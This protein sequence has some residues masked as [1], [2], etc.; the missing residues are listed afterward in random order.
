MN[1]N[2]K[3]ILILNGSLGGAEG[4]SSVLIN[5][6]IE[7]LKKHS[8]SIEVIH[9]KNNQNDLEAKLK[10]ADGF[11]FVSGTY[12]DSWGSPLQLFLEKS[13]EYEASD[14]FLYKP[15]SVIITM[16]SVGGKAILSR[17]QGV[18]NTIGMLI[19]PMSGL[20]YSLATHLNL[21]K[22][23]N[24]EDLSFH[25]DFWNL[26]DIEIVIHNLMTAVNHQQH[27]KSWP[28]DRKDPTR[29]WI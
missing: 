7:N 10:W 26:E 24:E 20:V 27:Y 4:N 15:A 1:L 9:L 25:D 11:L 28:V 29:R 13:T 19:P 23:H 18:L 12:W 17:L 14:L 16:H 8:A 5:L 2:S 6:A 22:V 3:N 21:K